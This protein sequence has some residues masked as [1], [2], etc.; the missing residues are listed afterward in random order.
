MKIKINFGMSL[1]LMVVLIFSAVNSFAAQLKK[2][3]AVSRF[4]AD[5]AGSEAAI[6]T[7]MADQLADAL[8]QSGDFIVIERQTLEDVINEQDIAASGRSSASQSARTGKIIPA[9]IL[10]K[11][12]ITEFDA[13]TSKGGT[14]LSI[15]GISLGSSKTT[16]HVA[17][18]LR[19][20]DTTS[21]EVLDSVRVEGEAR[22]K[23][24]KLGV[25]KGGVDFGTEDFKKTPLGE[26]TQ[27]A[28]DKAVIEIAQKLAEVPFEGRIIKI[29][30]DTIYTNV[31]ARNGVAAGAVLQVFSPGEELLDPVTGENLGS[32]KGLDVGA[33]KIDSMEEKFSKASA[34]SGGPFAVGM[35]LMGSQMEQAQGVK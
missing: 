19:I 25:E 26:A 5:A 30:G 24:I 17:V 2:T 34:Q 12:S 11:G 27:I 35:K 7:G 10:I 6:G 16:A 21:A 4:E 20:I 33:L 18:V 28:I 9:Q 13:E 8:I 14:G 1:L 31:G 32:E 3:I 22:A 23:G 15:S 29:E